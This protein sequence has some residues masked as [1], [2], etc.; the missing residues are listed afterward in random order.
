MR[1]G[2]LAITSIILVMLSGPPAWGGKSCGQKI[3]RVARG[4]YQDQLWDLAIGEFRRYLNLCPQEKLVPVAH[5]LLAESLYKREDLKAAISEYQVLTK[6]YPSFSSLDQVWYRLGDCHYRLGRH[7]R[8]A[9]AFQQL[10][11]NFPKSSQITA[12]FLG[13]AESYTTLGKYNQA[14][15]A[16]AGFL[17]AARR[18]SI[19][20]EPPLFMEPPG[21][22]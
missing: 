4:A 11:S 19:P 3:W 17:E 2:Y 9:E 8:A 16:Y 21:C 12:A 5:L 20:G 6:Y 13:A 22:R 10:I 7:S 14:E 18:L 1:R 15:K